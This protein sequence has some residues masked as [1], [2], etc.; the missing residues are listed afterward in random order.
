MLRRRVTLGAVL[1][2]A[3]CLATASFASAAPAPDGP[4][5]PLTNAARIKSLTAEATVWGLPAEFVYRFENFNALVT[6]PRNQFGGGGTAAAW[7]NNATNAG[8]ASVLYLNAMLD[9]SGRKGRGGTKELVL[10]VPPSRNDYYVVNILD[11]FINTVGSIGTRTTPSAKAQTYLLA[12]PTSQYAHRRVARING[13]TYRVMTSDTN[14]NWMLIRIRADTLVPPGNSASAAVV[15]KKVVERFALNTLAQF[16]RRKHHPKYFTPGTMNSTAGQLKRSHVWQNAPKR[17]TAFFAQMGHALTSSPIP[18]RGTGLE[19]TPM[20][21]VPAWAV[22]AYDTKR[23]FRNPSGGQERTLARFRNLGLTADGWRMPRNW[24]AP[25]RAAFQ[26]GFEVGMQRVNAALN[27]VAVSPESNY[28]SYLNDKVGTYP[29]TVT[30]YLYRALI[31][32]AGGGANFPLDAIYAQIN[33]TDGTDATQ[34][35][36]NRAYTVTF[37]P[38]VTDP[39]SLPVIGAMPPTVNDSAGN[40]RGFWS[41]HVYQTDPSQ[42]AAPF[43]TQASVLN[44]AY[45]RADLQVVSVDAVRNTIT[46]RPS[47]WGPLVASSPVM[48]GASAARYGL[49][50]N[51]PY[52]VVNTP[53]SGVSPGVGKTVTFSVTDV[54]RQPLSDNNVPIQAAAGTPGTTVDL[55]DP[56]APVDLSWGPVQPVSQLGSQQLTSGQLARN[57]D[58]SVTLWIGPRL[59]SGAPATNWLPTPSDQYNAGIY[60]NTQI[61]VEIRPMMRIYYPTPGSNT[62]ASILPPPNG[63]MTST[64]V[65]PKVVPVD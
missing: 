48:F 34:L 62:Q 51:T 61:P 6:A 20:R 53:V 52:Y 2:T 29:N 45:S 37:T 59:P 16:E 9:L 63:A 38:P 60:P 65:L 46:A 18:P 58:G 13:F 64:Y 41:V 19:G 23:V 5:S 49:A 10:T 11:G 14:L 27:T 54:W 55:V 28:W 30:G 8:D 33:N 47:T 12:G 25:Q 42:S 26:A 21:V 17:A 22:P 36:G 15:K 32:L 57:T 50:P 44:T 1:G 56:G 39:L 35:D 3:C 43:I 40:P 24:R 4:S 31:V 7:N